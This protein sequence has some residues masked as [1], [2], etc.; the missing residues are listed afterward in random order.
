MGLAFHNHHDVYGCF[1]SGGGGW[2]EDRTFNS[3]GTPCI[4]DKQK[5]GWAYQ[6]LPFIE[7]DNVWRDPSNANVAGDQIKIYIC[8][9]VRAATKYQYSQTA[10]YNGRTLMD[11]VGNGG[12]SGNW[13]SF[14]TATNSLDGPIVPMS[15][16]SART[17]TYA[18]ITDGSSNTLLIGEKWQYVFRSSPDCNNDQGWTDGWDNDTVCYAVGYPGVSPYTGQP[19]PPQPN[20]PGNGSTCGGV[21]GSSHTGGMVCVF[22]DGSG[23]FVNFGIPVTTWAN[24]ISATDGR[25]MDFQ[26]IN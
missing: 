4:Y 10:G 16:Y 26:G 2:W 25:P 15:S 21:F 3:N 6:I 5:W 18:S 12:T 8:P 9:S 1:A 17:V 7:Q 19:I 22:C 20:P 23:H 14:T 13:G 11:Y 24:L